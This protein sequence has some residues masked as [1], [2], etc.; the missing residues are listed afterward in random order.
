M[1]RGP[2]D[3]KELGFYFELS[4]VGME[5]VVPIVVGLAV[6]HYLNWAPWGVVVGA[7]LGLVGGMAHLISLVNRRTKEPPPG[8]PRDGM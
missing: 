2:F 3:P 6:D 4:Q 8:A 7:V 5:M 1:P